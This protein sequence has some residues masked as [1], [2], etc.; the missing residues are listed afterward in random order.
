MIIKSDSRMLFF[1]SG[2]E[3]EMYQKQGANDK[4]T[5]IFYG[6]FVVHFVTLFIHS[7]I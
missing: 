3:Q 5:D 4:D 2:K 6:Y 1:I 7:F